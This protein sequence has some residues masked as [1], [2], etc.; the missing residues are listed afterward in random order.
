MKES[1]TDVRPPIPGR[2]AASGQAATEMNDMARKAVDEAFAA[3]EAA[4][5]GQSKHMVDQMLKIAT[6]GELL[7][8][9]PVVKP[10]ETQQTVF[11]R[12]LAE[13]LKTFKAGLEQTRSRPAVQVPLS[14]F[15]GDACPDCRKSGTSRSKV[16]VA[17]KKEYDKNPERYRRLMAEDLK[18]RP[19]SRVKCAKCGKAKAIVGFSMCLPCVE[20]NRADATAFMER[21]RKAG[22]CPYCGKQKDSK[23]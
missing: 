21:R 9:K 14:G 23:A 13:G 18:S 12:M 4:G 6:M 17:A 22:L 3:S 7:G 8:P 2:P 11:A 10:G 20:K 1:Q 19:D 16:M 5:A 15:S